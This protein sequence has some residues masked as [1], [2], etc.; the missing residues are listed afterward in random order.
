MWSIPSYFLPLTPTLTVLPLGNFCPIVND[1]LAGLSSSVYNTFVH[2]LLDN[3]EVLNIG[4][5][6]FYFVLWPTNAQLFHKLSYSYMFRHCRVFLK[7]LVIITLPSDIWLNQLSNTTNL[8]WI[9]VYYLVINC[10]DG[11]PHPITLPPILRIK[12]ACQM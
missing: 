7:E 6:F 2:C 4:C 5:W 12:D 10:M 11:Y 9:D 3:S 1:V 8:W